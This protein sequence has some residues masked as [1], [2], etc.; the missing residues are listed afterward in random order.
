[1]TIRTA[2]AALGP[3]SVVSRFFRTLLEEPN[4]NPALEVFPSNFFGQSGAASRNS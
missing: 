3:D 4:A 2:L 1:M